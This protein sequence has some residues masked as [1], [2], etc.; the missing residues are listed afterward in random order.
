M[1]TTA[2]SLAPTHSFGL[3]HSPLLTD[4]GTPLPL[5]GRRIGRTCLEMVAAVL[6]AAAVS[7]VVQLVVNR[8]H[9]PR[10]SSVTIAMTS[11]VSVAAL[12]A[13]L[14]LATRRTFGVVANV[15]AWVGL[16]V[17]NTAVLAFMLQGTSYYLG[18]ISSDQSF[19]TQY[20]TRLTDSATVHD[21]AFQGV[22]SYYPSG[23]FWLAARF[24]DLFGLAGWEAYKPFAILTFAVTAVLAFAAWSL[25]VPRRTA[26]L[27][28]VATSTVGVATWAAYEPYAW[29]FGALIPPMAAV[30]WQYLTNDR[31]LPGIFV[32]GYVGLLALFY[33]LLLAF[34]AMVVV[35]IAVV[36]LILA[37][38]RERR[39]VWQVAARLAVVAATSVVIA[40]VHWA[41]Y[42]AGVLD[43]PIQQ[44]AASRI[45]P[46]FGAKFPVPI[47][48]SSFLGVLS[49]AGLVWL[50]V[51]VRDGL[52]PRAM[53]LVTAA[54][55]L[56]YALSML[57]IRFGITLLPYKIE[58]VMDVVL[59]CAGALALVD[60][61]RW[62]ATAVAEQ[63]RRTAV[64]S[65]TVLS[66]L[67]TAGVLQSAKDPLAPLPDL[68]YSSYYPTGTTPDG[69]RDPRD[70]G[71]WNQRLHDTIAQLTG[72]PEHDSTVLADYQD[73]L[74]FWPYWDFETTIIEYA[75]PLAD[76][77][78]RRD[79]IIS[80]SKA[81]SP[82]QL[83]SE[84]D[85]SRFTPPNVLVFTRK[86][87]GLHMTV[88]RNIF[89][90]YP[91]I[92]ATSLVFP[93]HLFASDRFV[94]RDVGP[95]TVVV[96]TR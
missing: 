72:K 40:A 62:L 21:F 84:M 51:R 76:F 75:N 66:V 70:N 61:A 82:A 71:A 87:D 36:A 39:F 85:G 30:A 29:V 86:D 68:A 58:L 94:T 63:W 22:P 47:N 96:R 57:G 60:L 1:T 33:T 44:N 88:T 54:G 77:D 37:W 4:P 73:F 14:W 48:L 15:V 8:L 26:V 69:K 93:Q 52:L 49:L 2:P 53:L 59:R 9:I 20:L 90:V 92:E 81:D 23:W 80:W 10:P 89:P 67:G 55:Y 64:A 50:V 6:V 24:A 34:V 91:Q 16:S 32:G 43:T 38:R 7:L 17:L 78:T 41:P 28:A 19:R 74:S 12:V 31:W 56:W 35:L 65:L 42:L 11:L 13:A 45:L 27:L 5:T 18:G 3:N 46:D 95:F 79:E 25:V 83:V